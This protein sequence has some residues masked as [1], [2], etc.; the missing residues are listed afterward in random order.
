MSSENCMMLSLEKI[1]IDSI[2][3]DLIEIGGFRQTI[4]ATGSAKLVKPLPDGGR[5]HIKEITQ[6]FI[7]FDIDPDD[8]N[9][10]AG[11]I[12]HTKS[13]INWKRNREPNNT[14]KVKVKTV[15]KNLLYFDWVKEYEKDFQ[16]Y[17]HPDGYKDYK[18]KQITRFQRFK[19][20]F[21]RIFN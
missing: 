13:Y 4:L 2:K 16:F 21:K 11:L 5:V 15:M 14:K 20:Y 19:N 6:K 17:Y 9:N 18:R 1:L 8:P 7:Y 12:D 10:L 3:K